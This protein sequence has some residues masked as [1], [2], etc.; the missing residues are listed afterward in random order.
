MIG[1]MYGSALGLATA[2]LATL[3]VSGCVTT[4]S[5]QAVKQGIRLDQAQLAKSFRDIRSLSL[6]FEAELVQ[7]IG[8]DETETPPL[9]IEFAGERTF[10]TLFAL[11][12]W[13]EPYSINIA[14]HMFGGVADPA[15]F[16][17]RY[18]LLNEDFS[19][20]RQSRAQD[21]VYRT[22]MGE[23]MIA[24]TLF[25]NE[26]NRKERYIAIIGEPRTTVA[27]H[28]SL[29]QSEGTVP[30]V[31]P[32]KG[33]SLTWLIRTGGNEGPKRMR[34]AAGGIVRVKADVYKPKRIGS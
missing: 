16:Y 12:A 30:L 21:F 13:T 10:V 6:P 1:G 8:M 3:V 20:S 29:T 18:V 34:A 33:G 23:G 17:P 11:P 31:I 15:I 26:E 5:Q 4:G 25:V 24:S 2:F 7:R 14:S 27:E 9:A 32:V 22:G 28:L 19:V